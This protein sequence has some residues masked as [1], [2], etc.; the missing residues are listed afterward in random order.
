[1]SFNAWRLPWKGEQVPHCVLDI[2]R[3]CNISC[4]ACYNTLPAYNKSPRQAEAELDAMLA[5]RRLSSLTILGGEATLHPNLCE[6]V[7]MAKGKGLCVELLTNGVLLDKALASRLRD[8]GTTIIYLHIEVGQKRPDL[9]A[10]S[11][12]V[13]VK[14]LISEKVSVIAS[15]G[16]DAGLAM[17][18]HGDRL[19]EVKDMIRFALE[20]PRVN[21]LLVT[22]FRDVDNISLI[23]GDLETGMQGLL[24]NSSEGANKDN[25][26]A[27]MVNSYL[28]KELGLE[29]FAYLG[30]NLDSGDPRWLSY[31]VGTLKKADGK[32]TWQ[33]F[34]ASRFERAF[35]W[36][37]KLVAG[38]YPMYQKQNPMAFRLQLLLNALLG[39][40]FF[41]NLK[42][43]A[44]SLLPGAK[45][46][47]KRF[48]LQCPARVDDKGRVVHCA[49]CPDAIIK[50]GRLVPVCISDQIR[51]GP[52][53]ADGMAP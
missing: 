2:N 8:A 44:G 34:K 6:I 30:S 45:V 41:R 35:L 18:A 7:A 53:Q 5:R 17:T 21:Y 12:F 26:T 15:S 52:E 48:L 22:L 37:S 51:S 23:T 11:S 42:F 43:L 29:P 50:D 14:N 9:P 3:G 4:R 40:N 16:L 1:M 33:S 25:L 24:K 49:E 19:S 13:Q 38:R 47:A 36:I 27:Q 10:D 20:T 31:L 28:E 32:S 46:V 39:G